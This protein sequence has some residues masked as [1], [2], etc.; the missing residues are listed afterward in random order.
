MEGF[1]LILTMEGPTTVPTWSLP[2]GSSD[3]EVKLN[4]FS[5]HGR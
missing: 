5:E 4:Y 3:I 1:A 2:T